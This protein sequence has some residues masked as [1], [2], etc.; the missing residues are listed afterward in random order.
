MDWLVL[1]SWGAKMLLLDPKSWRFPQIIIQVIGHRKFVDLP[2]YN[3]QCG[4][5]QL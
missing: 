2:D 5:P 3:M 1:V 4:A